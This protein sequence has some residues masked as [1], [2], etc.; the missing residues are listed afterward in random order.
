[1]YV[2]FLT[3]NGFRKKIL[4]LKNPVMDHHDFNTLYKNNKY[5]SVV[6]LCVFLQ[7]KINFNEL[8]SCPNV[9]CKF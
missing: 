9:T 3:E 2:A 5:L 8:P 6:K 4:I 7:N 1:M